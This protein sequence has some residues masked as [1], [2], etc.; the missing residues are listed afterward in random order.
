[1]TPLIKLDKIDIIYNQ[2]EGFKEVRALTDISLAIFP[3]EYVI[4]FGPSGCGKSTLMNV[5]AGLEKISAGSV[6]VADRD[7]S[8]LTDEEMA[9]YHRH[10]VGF[11]FQA[12][13]LIPT[14]SVL[15]NIALPQMFEG[16][17]KMKWR[18]NA[19]KLARRF[20]ITDHVK[21]LPQELSGGQQQR[22]GV[23]RALINNPSI[24]L[25]DEPAGNLDSKNARN[26]LDIFQVLN[27]EE[28]KTILMV[29]HSPDN[30]GEADRIFYLKDGRIVDEVRNKER[31]RNKIT[32]IL[33]ERKKNSHGAMPWKRFFKNAFVPPSLKAEKTARFLL[34]VPPEHR[35]ARFTNLIEKRLQG[36][37]DKFEFESNLDKPYHQGGAGLN[38]RTARKISKMTDHILLNAQAIHQ[39]PTLPAEKTERVIALLRANLETTNGLKLN[40]DQKLILTTIFKDRLVNK[41]DPWQVKKKLDISVS[42]GG[43]GLRRDTAN[44]VMEYL[45]LIVLISGSVPLYQP[46]AKKTTLPETSKFIKQAEKNKV[47][48]NQIK[49]ILEGKIKLLPAG[50]SQ[51]PLQLNSGKTA[52]NRLLKTRRLFW[53]F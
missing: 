42:Q 18:E 52:N 39:L 7:L 53:R 45:E 23:A 27:L 33:D 46:K 8:K 32:S 26:M 21:R 35:V 3:R 15:E 14:L 28:K 2:G 30:L 4:F 48:I 43:L 24:L 17:S 12:Y 25:A 19:Y 5:I 31:R 10:Q 40:Q 38:S 22:V 9:T 6:L 29:T 50:K 20:D 44:K 11:I 47:A 1:M 36:I 34:G 41:I 16:L 51:P 49:N 13:N 37:I